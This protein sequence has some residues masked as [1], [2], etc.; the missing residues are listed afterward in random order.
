LDQQDFQVFEN[1]QRQ[2]TVVAFRRENGL[3]LRLGIMVHTRSSQLPLDRAVRDFL[4]VV[5]KPGDQAFLAGFDTSSD[6]VVDFTNDI[7]YLA[8]GLRSL[9]P[10]SEAV[11]YD[12]V[13]YACPWRI[14]N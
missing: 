9:R 6:L 1:G 12:A 4:A 14:T 10:G 8:K 13:F 7:E 5:L 2:D 11:I 3:P